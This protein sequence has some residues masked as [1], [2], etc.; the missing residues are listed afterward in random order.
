MKTKLSL[1]GVLASLLLGAC[2]EKH[3]T[4]RLCNRKTRRRNGHRSESR[5]GT[6]KIPVRN[7]RGRTACRFRHRT[8]D[9]P[10][11]T[12]RNRQPPPGRL[13]RTLRRGRIREIAPTES[14]SRFTAARA[15]GRSTA[16]THCWKSISA[17]ANTPP[18]RSWCRTPQS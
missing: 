2:S 5:I 12:D 10:G 16:F 4:E 3:R 1:I 18:N 8:A 6:T 9:R 11:D 17:A 7:F 14:G 15:T 13:A